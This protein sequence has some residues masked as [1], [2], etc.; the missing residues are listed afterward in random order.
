[1]GNNNDQEE[2]LETSQ[3]KNQYEEKSD[4]YSSSD[5]QYQDHDDIYEENKNRYKPK[6]QKKYATKSSLALSMIV[7]I[8]FSGL[9]GF[10]GGV[11]ALRVN[12][13]MNPIRIN[14][15]EDGSSGYSSEK[16]ASVAAVVDGCADSVVEITTETVTTGNFMHQYISEGAG[17]GIILSE[18]GYIATNNHVIQGASKVVVTLRDGKKYEASL[19]ASDAK[20]DIALLKID[21]T[22]LKPVVF[23]DSDALKV[24]ELA[25]AIGNPLGQLGGTVTDGIISAL[26]RDITIDGD[27]KNLLQTNAAINPGNSGGGLFNEQGH[28]IGLV[29]AKS[30]GSDVEGLGFAIPSNDVKHVIEELSQYGYVRGRVAFEMSLMDIDSLQMALMYRVPQTGVY[31]SKVNPGSNAEEAG[32][33]A[34]DCILSVN[35]IDVKTS[36]DVEK[37]INSRS[38]GDSVN[39]VVMRNKQNV[40]LSLTLKEYVPENIKK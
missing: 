15:A 17:S 39:F 5:D 9:L 14:S 4:E 3:T 32:F 19:K 25:V 12:E 20:V 1:M 35:S 31:I 27:T 23:A 38:V 33:K 16:L 6:K 24:G 29:I 26:N 37:I 7:C 36:S 18:D 21:E 10:G 2:L 11:I 22:G 34:G 8:L 28:L 13:G 30:S 40:S